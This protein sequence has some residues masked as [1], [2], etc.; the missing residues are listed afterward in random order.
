[1]ARFTEVVRITAAEPFT[2]SLDNGLSRQS[3][4]PGEMYELPLFAAQGMIARGWAV[5]IDRN[6]VE[7]TAGDLPNP[8]TKR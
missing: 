8:L 1:M 4:Q 3:Y 7:E 5:I 2:W 6:A